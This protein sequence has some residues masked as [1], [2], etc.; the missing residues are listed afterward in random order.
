[1]LGAFQSALA[2]LTA[3]PALCRAVRADPAILTARFDL[4]P[5][6]AE[7]LRGIVASKGM[8]ANCILYRANRLAPVALNCPDLCRAMGPALLEEAFTAYWEAER[9]TDV[10]FL[11][12]TDRF[13]RF[14]SGRRDL[15]EGVRAALDREH[16][17]VVARLAA[18]RSQAGIPAFRIRAPLAAAAS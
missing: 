13:C 1:M 8:E 2:E 17:I 6:E 5:R 16:A 18:S 9:R 3:S 12:E 7:R 10:H 15:P 14:L 11:V 4:T